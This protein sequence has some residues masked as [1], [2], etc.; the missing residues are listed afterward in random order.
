MPKLV[1]V[2]L[3]LALA[4]AA[5]KAV[6]WPLLAPILS[7][8]SY[9]VNTVVT[10]NCVTTQRGSYWHPFAFP[11]VARV[12]KH[13]GKT[14]SRISLCPGLIAN[15][16]TRS[17]SP[18]TGLAVLETTRCCSKC[19][20]EYSRVSRFTLLWRCGNVAWGVTGRVAG[21]RMHTALKR[22]R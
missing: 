16:S 13:A 14:E 4:A 6:L 11:S 21:G 10:G 8:L 2:L 5:G 1:K 9:Y 15:P 12:H 19:R 3:A 17:S 20:G 22:Q 7:E 18:E